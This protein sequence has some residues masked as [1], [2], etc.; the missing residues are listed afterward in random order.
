MKKI[1]LYITLA[2]LLGACTEEV[3]EQNLVVKEDEA[4]QLPMDAKEGELLIKFDS[5][6]TNL[7]DETFKSSAVSSRSGIPTTDEIL[8]I[9]GAY[10]FERVFPIDP[11]TEARS[12]EAGLHLWYL[13]RFDENVD[14]KK[15]V[16]QLSQLGEISKVQCNR[17]RKSVV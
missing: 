10:H 17:D 3:L 1:C 4:I 16:N 12:R 7:L 13:V 6:M 9:L 2:L 5:E 15:A 14:L 8:D 11:R